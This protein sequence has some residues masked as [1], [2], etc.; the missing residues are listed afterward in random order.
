[1]TM[2]SSR[3]F[4]TR[5][6][7]FLL[8]TIA[9]TILVDVATAFVP[10]S[11]TSL[12]VLQRSHHQLQ[13]HCSSSSSTTQLY[14]ANS[15]NNAPSSHSSSSSNS[16]HERFRKV[17]AA[18]ATS[19]SMYYVSE[20]SVQELDRVRASFELLLQRHHLYYSTGNMISS[21]SSS[22]SAA[23][24]AAASSMHQP[25][26]L[27]LEVYYPEGV[28]HPPT[29]DSSP[30]T[31][32]SEQYS[33]NY[34]E[35]ENDDDDNNHRLL[36]SSGRR[37]RELEIQLLASLR[38]NDDGIDQLVHL[39]TTE[40]NADAAHALLQM[41]NQNQECSHGL[42]KEEGDLAELCRI[43]PGWA[44][45]WSRLAT[46]LFYKGVAR[47]SDALSAAEEAIR[48][49]PWHF[50]ALN[51]CTLILTLMDHPDNPSVIFGDDASVEDLRR[52]CNRL[53]RLAI[54]KLDAK[55][56]S[57]NKDALEARQVWVSRAVAT[58]QHQLQCAE[59]YT[60]ARK[61]QSVQSSSSQ[62]QHHHH[63]LRTPQAVQM[64]NH[65]DAMSLN[66]WQ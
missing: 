41:Q 18:A 46:L 14:Y 8:L 50:E 5:W 26:Q 60:A 65:H 19:R 32:A 4:R 58:A 11:T 34:I 52:R 45:P 9:V 23:A 66:A 48:I 54:P 31:A 10:A 51:V 30:S 2:I 33:Q 12:V 3:T 42:I 55:A 16:D 40:R 29:F 21:T 59:Q 64:S 37:L 1:M 63:R 62:Q 20:M 56:N 47:W 36:T 6:C 44:E 27:G 25:H 22:T 53:S 43:Y 61:M 28:I 17:I 57:N 38:D 39:W 49:K 15:N 13:Q 7:N 24:A 35:A